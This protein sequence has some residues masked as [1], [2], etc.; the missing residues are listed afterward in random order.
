MK[1]SII[2]PLYNKKN[3]IKS[4]I[5]SVLS[6]T[7]NDWELLIV[8]NG[9]TDGSIEEAKTIKDTRV[10]YLISPIR[11]VCAARNYGLNFAKGEWIQFLDADDLLETSHLSNMLE[12]AECHPHADI[13]ACGWQEFIDDLPDK[14][15]VKRPIGEN[16]DSKLLRDGA[17]AYAPW[18]VH[19]ALIKRIT[20]TPDNYWPVTL[21]NYLAED[22][23]FWFNLITQFSVA[24]CN[25]A[26]ALY[27]LQ[28]N[29]RSQGNH[30][31]EWYRGVDFAIKYNVN[32]LKQKNKTITLSQAEI[33]TSIYT[34]LCR[35]SI[36]N[37]L[38][39]LTD[40]LSIEATIWLNMCLN[41]SSELKISFLLRK[42]FG[43][44]FFAY[45]EIYLLSL[46]RTFL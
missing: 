33:L 30:S 35:F 4:T 31:I 25:S 27:R 34:G 36:E 39:H 9:S 10:K 46:W 38:F 12:V 7:F 41:I 40:E 32:L 43:I 5:K 3:Y 23:V 44:R 11:G 19:A 15:V 28:T 2:V 17:I 18:A 29:G 6:Q 45:I 22:T 8:D 16:T 26:G 21:D 13:I 24:Y 37:Q 20:M 14:R 42:I 1:V